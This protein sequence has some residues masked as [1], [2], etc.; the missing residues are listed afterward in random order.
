MHA[1]APVP[2]PNVPAEHEAHELLPPLPA[3]V[4]AAQLEQLDLPEPW[5]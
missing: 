2:L 3:K 4:L 1:E 5:E